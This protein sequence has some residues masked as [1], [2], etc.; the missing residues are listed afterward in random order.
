MSCEEE[1]D[2]CHVR[3]RIHVS[4]AT[5]THVHVRGRLATFFM[6]TLTLI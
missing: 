1:E 3:R 4:H 5:E 2:T 6:P